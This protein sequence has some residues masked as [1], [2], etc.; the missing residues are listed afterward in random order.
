MP[1]GSFVYYRLH[2]IPISIPP[3][4]E[5]KEDIPLLCEHYQ[6]IFSEQYHRKLHLSQENITCW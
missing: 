2:V 4:G 5:R 3:L 1:M 6:E